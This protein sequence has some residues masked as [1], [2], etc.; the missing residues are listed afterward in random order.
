MTGDGNDVTT[1]QQTEEDDNGPIHA[2]IG[3]PLIRYWRVVNIV[4]RVFQMLSQWIQYWSYLPLRARVGWSAYGIVINWLVT[5]TILYIRCLFFI[6]KMSNFTVRWEIKARTPSFDVWSGSLDRS[7]AA[8]PWRIAQATMQL[9][10][11]LWQ[12]IPA[13]NQTVARRQCSTYLNF[14]CVW[15]LQGYVLF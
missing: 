4:A 10:Q 9:G 8:F 2:G 5:G 13:K 14:S 6:I 1:Q 7:P 15:L 11:S 12:A 3:P